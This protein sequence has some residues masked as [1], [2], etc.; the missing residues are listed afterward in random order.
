MWDG[1][2]MLVCSTSNRGNQL[3]ENVDFGSKVSYPGV[4][5]ISRLQNGNFKHLATLGLH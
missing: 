1:L 3:T 4:G 2:S 5:T